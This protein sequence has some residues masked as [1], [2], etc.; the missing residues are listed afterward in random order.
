LGML[1]DLGHISALVA[2]RYRHCECLYIEFNHCRDLLQTGPYPPMLK[3]RVG[4]QWGHLSNCQASAFVQTLR[5]APLHTLIVGHISEKNNST[6]AVEQVLAE[7][8]FI[9]TVAISPQHAVQPWLQV[10]G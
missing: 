6:A 7:L 2:E 1:S 8:D 4:G 5:E 9:N 10:A 3:R